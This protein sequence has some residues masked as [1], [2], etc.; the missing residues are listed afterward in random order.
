MDSDFYFTLIICILFLSYGF[1]NLY[2]IIFFRETENYVVG[3][4]EFIAIFMGNIKNYMNMN[5]RFRKSAVLEG[6][7]LLF[8]RCIS[9]MHLLSPILIPIS[10]LFWVMSI[11]L[12]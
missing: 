10:I 8:N 2:I 11:G 9:I 6:N 4:F 1:S 7:N 5:K 3:L 12:Y